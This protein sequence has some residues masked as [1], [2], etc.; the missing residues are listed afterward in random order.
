M[1]GPLSRHQPEFRRLVAGQIAAGQTTA[2]L[3]A[4]RYELAEPIVERWVEAYR[5]LFAG[6][7]PEA[8]VAHRPDTAF[9]SHG[10]TLLGDLLAGADDLSPRSDG[11]GRSGDLDVLGPWL[12][13]LRD[14]LL[15]VEPRLAA[16]SALLHRFDDAPVRTALVL[17]GVLVAM[18]EALRETTEVIGWKPL[19]IDGLSAVDLIRARIGDTAFG[20]S[21]VPLGR[22]TEILMRP[23][24]IRR[25]F[26]EPLTEAVWA[27][28]HAAAA[29]TGGSMA[30]GAASERWAE[31]VRRIHRGLSTHVAR[32]HCALSGAAWSGDP[33]RALAGTATAVAAARW[34]LAAN[35][36]IGPE[37]VPTEAR[38]TA[39]A[40][41]AIELADEL[42]PAV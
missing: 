22:V 28:V 32:V 8:E 7:E 16:Q 20:R 11:S 14:P 15:P 19:E 1:T 39:A 25:V 33:H 31:P 24:R 27:T 4:A 3:V 35:E 13:S 10:L 40:E 17:A 36:V 34:L 38:L 23:E 5:Q 37:W 26:P 21:H 29:E 41:S 6:D 9:P 12:I 2:S 42:F 18:G 30:V